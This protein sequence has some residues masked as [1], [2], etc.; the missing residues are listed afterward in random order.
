M[1]KQPYL[2][3]IGEKAEAIAERFQDR[4]ITTQEMLKELEE[5]IKE[6][7]EAR[8]EQAKSN[9]PSEVFS[10]YWMFKKEGVGEP[11][12]KTNEM[13]AVMEEY[14]YWKTSQSHER[15]VRQ[16]LYKVLVKSGIDNVAD[17]AKK[18]IRVMK[19]EF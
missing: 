16:E 5:L 8:K 1:E 14:P 6:I 11:E 15:S 3:S 7:N 2:I 10:V 18:I 12:E 9:I 17:I 13:K 19:G 4:Q